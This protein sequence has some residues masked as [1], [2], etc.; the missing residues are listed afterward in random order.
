MALQAQCAS[1]TAPN[2][3]RVTQGRVCLLHDDV[4][5]EALQLQQARRDATFVSEGEKCKFRQP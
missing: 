5:F 3:N 2:L 4:E 1:R